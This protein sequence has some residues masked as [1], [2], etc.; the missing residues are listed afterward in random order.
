[1]KI[2][3]SS[4]VVDLEEEE[5]KGKTCMEMVEATTKNEETSTEI[6]PQNESS[7]KVFISRKYIFGQT[8]RAVYQSKGDL[9]NQ[10]AMK[11]SMENSEIRDLL[12]EVESASQHK[13]SLLSV[14]DVEKKTFKIAMADNDK[15]SEIKVHYENIVGCGAWLS[16]WCRGPLLSTVSIPHEVFTPQKYVHS[17]TRGSAEGVPPLWGP[18]CP[19]PRLGGLGESEPP[20]GVRGQ[21]PPKQKLPYKSIL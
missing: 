3:S 4:Q 19:S 10:Y 17:S 21:R 14:R 12:P 8:P 13:A 11:G 6:R 2:T 15:V 20:A 16:S 18:G 1:M 5:L 9:M 7:T